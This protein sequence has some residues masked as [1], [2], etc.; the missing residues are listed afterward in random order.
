MTLCIVQIP[1]TKEDPGEDH[2]DSISVSITQLVRALDCSS[3]G[4]RFKSD[5]GELFVKYK[6]DHIHV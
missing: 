3:K 1:E 2:A 6:R 5:P 4:Q